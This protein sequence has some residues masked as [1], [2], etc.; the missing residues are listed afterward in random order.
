MDTVPLELITC[1]GFFCSIGGSL[2]GFFYIIF[3]LI[4]N[5]TI[6]GW[7]SLM[8]VMIVIGG[9]Q[10]LMLGIIGSYIGRIYIEALDRPLYTIDID[11]NLKVN[12]DL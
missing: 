7:A 4:T 3:S 9:L 1:I 10:I 11:T 12:E 6:S 2:L 5:N 8:F